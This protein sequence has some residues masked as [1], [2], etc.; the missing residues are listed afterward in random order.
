MKT[1]TVGEVARRSGLTVRTRHHYDE[2][3]LLEP[4]H[5]SPTG[6]RLYEPDD[7]ARLTQ[8]LILRR[9]GLALNE[10]R[11]V[12]ARPQGSLRETLG[13]QISHLKERIA[14]ESRL[15]RQLESM[16]R[17]LEQ[18]E[19]L[20]IDQ[21]TDLMEM[22]AMFEKYYTAEQLEYLEKRRRELG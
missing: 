1:M 4:A 3:G 15:L 13:Q 6:Y 17:R 20:S 19:R 10:I 5:R 2:I 9:L 14:L 8:I 16:H 18:S 7:V 11:E 12:L 21:L 22:M